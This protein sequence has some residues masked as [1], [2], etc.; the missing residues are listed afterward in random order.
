MPGMFCSWI[1][2]H[3]PKRLLLECWT[4]W[5]LLWAW[6]RLVQL[7]CS[8]S[9]GFPRIWNNSQRVQCSFSLSTQ[10][11]L[12]PGAAMIYQVRELCSEVLFSVFFCARSRNCTFQFSVLVL[13][14]VLTTIWMSMLSL[15]LV[16][17]RCPSCI[18]SIISPWR[19]SGMM[20]QFPVVSKPSVSDNSLLNAWKSLT[21]EGTSRACSGHPILIKC[22]TL[23]NFSSCC[24]AS[25]ISFIYF[26]LKQA[27]YQQ[28][29][30]HSSWRP[31]WWFCPQCCFVGFNIRCLLQQVFYLK[32]TQL[33]QWIS[34]WVKVSGIWSKHCPNLYSL[35]KEPAACGL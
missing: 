14:I 15:H 11:N 1:E 34:V 33:S 9:V 24:V 5:M 3:Y 23:S 12:P 19:D 2:G 16:K 32:H 17:P 22:F 27:V 35:S 4:V 25:R 28:L 30:W 31:L 26:F 29:R 8:I 18:C 7:W 10:I 21:K 20:I 13:R 6:W